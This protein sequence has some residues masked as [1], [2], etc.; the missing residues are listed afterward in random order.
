MLEFVRVNHNVRGYTVMRVYKD[1]RFVGEVYRLSE[2]AGWMTDK[3][4][5]APQRSPQAAAQYL[6]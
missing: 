3:P 5:L 1:G 2:D 4:G 6:L